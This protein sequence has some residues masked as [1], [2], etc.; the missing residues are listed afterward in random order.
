MMMITIECPGTNQQLNYDDDCDGGDEEWWQLDVQE[1]TNN[2]NYDNN[3]DNNDDDNNN[4]DNNDDG[5]QWCQ[6]D[7]QESINSPLVPTILQLQIPQNCVKRNWEMGKRKCSANLVPAEKMGTHFVGI[8]YE[9]EEKKYI[10]IAAK[11]VLPKSQK[12]CLQPAKEGI[13]PKSLSFISEYPSG[14]H[15][16]V[17]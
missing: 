8:P 16:K 6:L 4:D 12:L 5:G 17:E 10:W 1:S 3:D 7:V 14:L 9:N 15:N 2:G 11:C 13:L